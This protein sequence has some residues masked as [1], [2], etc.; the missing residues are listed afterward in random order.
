MGVPVLEPHQAV[1]ASKVHEGLSNKP[2]E[3]RI[4]HRVPGCPVA[5][6]G[7]GWYTVVH[8]VLCDE[9]RLEEHTALAVARTRGV[10]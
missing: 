1:G 10:H 9:R 2:R 3:P 8:Q 6:Y 5:Y 7:L 4:A